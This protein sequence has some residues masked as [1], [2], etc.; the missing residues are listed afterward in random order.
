LVAL[1]NAHKRKNE[2]QSFIRILMIEEQRN[3][4]AIKK[5]TKRK[6]WDV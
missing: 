5:Q 4:K 2:K 6:S 3:L 1:V